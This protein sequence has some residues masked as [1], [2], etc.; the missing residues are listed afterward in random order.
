MKVTESIFLYFQG[1]ALLQGL[2]QAERDRGRELQPARS[3][4]CYTSPSAVPV[5]KPHFGI[6]SGSLFKGLRRENKCQLSN[7]RE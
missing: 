1:L 5:V 6:G 7:S 3:G 2:G 4:L